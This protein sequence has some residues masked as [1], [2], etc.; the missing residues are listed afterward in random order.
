MKKKIGFALLGLIVVFAGFLWY[1]FA[2]KNKI[3]GVG[4][5][6]PAVLLKPGS[7]LPELV[8]YDQAGNSYSLR[9]LLNMPVNILVLIS[10][11]HED[12]GEVCQRLQQVVGQFGQNAKLLGLTSDSPAA[13]YN[14]KSR[15]NLALPILFDR[16][17][18]FQRRY[19]IE[20]FPAFL[21]TNERRQI[22]RFS[23]GA[24][25]PKE[26]VLFYRSL[27]SGAP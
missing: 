11:A 4:R 26:A 24:P 9:V 25:L 22:I 10:T 14:F 8:V 6:D 18:L 15:Y 19:P 5:T 20:I 7:E 23:S 1:T 13:V 17:G 12:C 2:V 27:L 16:E 3:K 21:V